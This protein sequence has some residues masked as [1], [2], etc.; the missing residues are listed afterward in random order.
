MKAQMWETLHGYQLRSQCDGGARG[1]SAN[2]RYGCRRIAALDKRGLDWK[3]AISVV[4][5]RA[6]SVVG[7]KAGSVAELV[8][9]KCRAPCQAVSSVFSLQSAL[10][11]SFCQNFGCGPCDECSSLTQQVSYMLDKCPNH[12]NVGMSLQGWH[13]A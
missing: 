2:E 7:R 11:S 12:H 10:G 5:D 1:G 6:R 4:A 8:H 9:A 3:R 13:M